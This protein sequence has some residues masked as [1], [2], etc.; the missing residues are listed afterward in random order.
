M[1]YDAICFK[2]K[3]LATAYSESSDNCLSS[4]AFTTLLCEVKE[5][6]EARLELANGFAAEVGG[7][8]KFRMSLI[9]RQT[10]LLQ[11]F[12]VIPKNHNL[13]FTPHHLTFN[14]IYSF[15][16]HISNSI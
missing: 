11:I 8:W 10:Y 16:L 5:N 7:L 12:S 6:E 4:S 13:Y 2:E 3:Q 14:P 15:S 9:H 1:E